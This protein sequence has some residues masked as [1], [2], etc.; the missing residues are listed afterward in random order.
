MTPERRA[1][2]KRIAAAIVLAAACGVSSIDAQA[3]AAAVPA[4]RARPPQ[5]SQSVQDTFFSDAREKLVGARPAPPAGAT[6]I[7]PVATTPAPSPSAPSPAALESPTAGWSRL[8]A[9]EVV[10]DEIKAQQMRLSG[11][12]QNP[13]K[14]KAELKQARESMSLLAV[15]FGIVA[16]FDGDI[17]WKGAAGSI[18][19]AMAQADSHSE[20][21]S[22]ATYQQAKARAQDLQTL[23]RGGSPPAVDAGKPQGSKLAD[24]PPL[25]R[26]L[27]QAQQ[28]GIAPLTASTGAFERDVDRL[29]HEAQL[30]AALG[31][32]IMREGYEFAEDET[33]LDYARSMQSEA[34]K[35]R[36]AARQKNFEQAQQ[37]GVALERTCNECHAAYRD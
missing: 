7:A 14:F 2:C 20:Q 34:L 24:R 21:A 9:A 11:L 32:V 8:I 37:A 1:W 16:E 17:R 36:D 22:D 26:R 5:F 23:I 35:V 31:E 4:R 10:E 29:A 25:M 33:Y 19:D 28:H 15:L 18:R 6:T 3:A 13:A 30:V 27:E 12:V